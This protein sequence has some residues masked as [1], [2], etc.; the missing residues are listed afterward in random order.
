MS[1]ADA[2]ARLADRLAE[3]D[4]H[5]GRAAQMRAKA[6]ID[7]LESAIER[8]RR[9]VDEIVKRR[10]EIQ[11]VGE[12]PDAAAQAYLAT[13]TA[14]VHGELEALEAERQELQLA[15][16]GLTVRVGDAHRNDRHPGG[17]L[18]NALQSVGS[19]F[20]DAIEPEIERVCGELAG[21][22]AILA[23]TGEAL[24]NGRLERPAAAIRR[25]LVH[26]REAGLAPP[27]VD[28]PGDLR[29]ALE[30]GREAFDLCRLRSRASYE[31]RSTADD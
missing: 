12:D 29:T 20:A 2:M 6:E 8:A 22:Y 14:T 5:D 30:H 27:T 19:E 26:L 15:I 16:R 21:L 13:G 31:I 11:T 18:R 1:R 28:V 9:R 25:A 24:V 4:L 3:L 7:E 10:A 17:P 23:A